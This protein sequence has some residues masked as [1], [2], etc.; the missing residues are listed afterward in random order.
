MTT[1]TFAAASERVTIEGDLAFVQDEYRRR[2]WSD[3]L[4]VVPATEEAVDEM[5]GAFEPWRESSLGPVPPRYGEATLEALAVNAVMAGCRPAHFATIVTAVEAMLRPEF[6]LYNIQATT[7]P[8]APLLVVHGPIARELEINGSSGAFG[9]GPA[10]NGA[11][12][13]TIRLILQNVGG[14]HAGSGDRA[15]QGSPSKFAFCCTENV[16]E[17]PWPELHTTRGYRAESSCVTVV[18][19]EGPQNVQDHESSEPG[20]L[21]DNVASTLG[22]LGHN[23]WFLSKGTDCVVGLSPEHAAVIARAGWDRGDVQRYLYGRAMRSGDELTGGGLWKARDWPRW[24]NELA[25]TGTRSVPAVRSPEDLLVLVV[26]G[27]GKHS[28]VL[29]PFGA[30]RAITLE[31]T[32]P[33]KWDSRHSGDGREEDDDTR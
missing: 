30:S 15:T 1:P 29:P 28:V 5:L 11:I 4:P 13:R 33:E 19:C 10:P 7:H 32:T 27:E 6:N 20:P 12:G 9:P 25:E 23:G 18:G 21:L 14:A 24:M 17:S 8:V 3:G 2:R 26:G 16:A 31:L 22:H